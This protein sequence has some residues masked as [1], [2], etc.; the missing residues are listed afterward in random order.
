M[1]TLDAISTY[2]ETVRRLP[3]WLRE[4]WI[5]T[6]HQ[7]AEAG[8]GFAAKMAWDAVRRASDEREKARKEQKM[9]DIQTDSKSL[10]LMDWQ[11]AVARAFEAQFSGM[12]SGMVS[13][14]HLI[15]YTE[16]SP[17]IWKVAYTLQRETASDGETEVVAGVTFAPREN[18]V[19][20]VPVYA[21]MKLFEQEDGRFRWL[22]VSSGGW[23][24]WD[25]EIVSTAFL[26]D[27]VQRA[28]K[29]NERGE[30]WV[31]HVPGTRI[32][33][34][35]YQA[36][37]D[38]FLLESGL[39]DQTPMGERAKTYLA[40]HPDTEVSI[41]FAYRN[42]SKDGV[43]SPPGFIIERSILPAGAA[44][45]PWSSISL[46][47][48][49][50]M[51]SISEPKRKALSDI[52]G[53]A[54]ADEVLSGI[55]RGAQVLQTA[56]VRYKEL[57]AA[58]PAAEA[59]PPQDGV[60]EVTQEFELSIEALDGIAE[61]LW[62]RVQQPVEASITPLIDQVGKL[63]AVVEAMSADVARLTEAEDDRLAEKAANLPRAT[64]RRILRP[65]QQQEKA[66]AELE[67]KQK[68]DSLLSTGMRTLYGD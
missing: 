29:M 27:C 30:L 5:G 24:D 56:G 40:E 36:L 51:A 63:R 28:D 20:V 38:G 26:E 3:G 17:L 10:N 57:A 18:W 52:L 13:D 49:D 61:K 60:L 7:N 9:T 22:A 37:S 2:P 15:G 46:M 64:V 68:A 42:R 35:D 43:Y 45:F 59:P 16:D 55:E 8:A 32:G 12:Y 54:V 23:E 58:E 31:A 66:L 39:L 4:T 34:C 41:T 25:G 62:Q 44:A 47:E 50:K 11:I 33:T 65:T 19:Q 1:P 53:E 21:A 48:M 6:Y 14:D 67:G